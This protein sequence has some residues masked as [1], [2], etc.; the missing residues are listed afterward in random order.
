MVLDLKRVKKKRVVC[1]TLAH[2]SMP[3]PPSKVIGTVSNSSNGSRYAVSRVVN[4]VGPDQFVTMDGLLQ[5]SE[6]FIIYS[7]FY[8]FIIFIIVL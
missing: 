7:F 8:I 5:G 2:F 1:R 3:L 4:C 6:I